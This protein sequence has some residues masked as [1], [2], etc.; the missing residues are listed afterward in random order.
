MYPHEFFDIESDPIELQLGSVQE[1]KTLRTY[2][3]ESLRC[4]PLADRGD[5][6]VASGLLSLVHENFEAFGTD[7]GEAIRSDAEI[8]LA[9]NV[10][11]AVLRRLDVNLPELPFRD[12]RTFKSYWRR[13]GMSSY[14]ARRDCLNA[15]FRPIVARL[16]QLEERAT[17]YTLARPVPPH[18]VLGWSRVDEEIAQL[19]FGF[20]AATTA[21]QYSN[22]GNACVRVLEALSEIV[23]DPEKHL[24]PGE[25][26]LPRDKT[27]E[28]FDRFIEAELPGSE[29]A[30][31]RKL[32]RAAIELAHRQKHRISPNRRDVG[33]TADAVI[34]LANLLRRLAEPA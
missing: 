28:R 11:R 9:L 3:L 32:A 18:E 31:L 13:E 29:N 34:L 20:S 17:E 5:L 4:G 16:A 8:A 23:H 19:R 27:K 14:Q 30:E 7:G 24:R 1:V 2:L 12:Y 15:F 25:P 10:L 6:E 21:Q 22:V 33:M 26:P